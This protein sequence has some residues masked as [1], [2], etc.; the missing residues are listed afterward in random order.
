MN[1]IELAKEKAKEFCNA[2]GHLNFNFTEVQLEAFATAIIDNY[3]AGLVPVAI[4]NKNTPSWYLQELIGVFKL[5][6]GTKLY[7]LGETK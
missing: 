4:V 3:K 7:A 5:D 2:G 1:V 6:N